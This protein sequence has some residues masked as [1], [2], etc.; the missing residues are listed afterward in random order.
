MTDDELDAIM[1]IMDAAFDPQWGEAWNRRQIA[2]ALTMS[3]THATL[4]GASGTAPAD[5]GESLGFAIVRAA[6]GE[7]EILLIAVMPQARRRG[8]GARLIATLAD[9]ARQR[10]ATRIFLEMRENNPARTLYVAEGFMPIGRRKNYYSLRDGARM[11]AITFA[12]DL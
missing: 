1:R 11:D 12:L 7:E 10:G 2:S 8:L 3:N 5:P 9:N 4:M 6:P